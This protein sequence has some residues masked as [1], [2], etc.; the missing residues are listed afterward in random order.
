MA[1]NYNIINS[2]PLIKLDE[3]RY[4]IP[5]VFLLFEAVYEAPF[6]WM[7]LEDKSYRNQLADNRGKVGEEIVY[8]LLLKTF[9]M[10][11]TFKSVKIIGKGN[12]VTDIDALCVLGSIALCVQVK[13]KKLT[14]LSSPIVSHCL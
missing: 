2:H 14:E 12:D 1:G 7:W 10:Q 9:G 3:E 8:D 5:I 13:S 4:F 11:R 6:Y